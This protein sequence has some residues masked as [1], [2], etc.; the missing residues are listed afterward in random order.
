MA[1]ISTTSIRFRAGDSDATGFL[2]WSEDELGQP[3]LIV[4]QEFWGLNTHIKDVTQRLAAEGFVALAPDMYDGKVTTDPTEARQW[5]MSMDQTAAL[6]KLIGAVDYLKGTPNVV[7]EKIGVIG[8]CMGGFLALNLACHSRDIRVATPFYGRI[9]PDSVLENLKAPVLYF[10]GEK[11]HHLPAA[12]VDRLEQFLKRT[13]RAGGVVRYPDADH[14][15]FNDTRKEVYREADAKDAWA[16]ALAFL[17]K[18]L[19]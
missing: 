12:D 10:F 7:K 4:L 19:A 13:G 16:K 18:Y 9:P 6:Q 11:D 5:L 17:R 15:F 2:A 1:N 3:G 14:A 8:F